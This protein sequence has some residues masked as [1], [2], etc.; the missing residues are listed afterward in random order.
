[1]ASYY[2]KFMSKFGII[3]K[4]LT[5]LL[6]KDTLFVWTKTTNQAFVA[7]KTALVQ[8]LVL[9]ILIFSKPFTIETDASGGGIGAVLQQDGHHIAYISR[10]LGPMILGLSTYEKECMAILFAVEQ[11]RSYLQH[12]EFMIRTDTRA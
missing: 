2:R 4:P 6:K 7:L 12:G 9:A 8:A 11:W 1:M 10:A 5:N 3:S